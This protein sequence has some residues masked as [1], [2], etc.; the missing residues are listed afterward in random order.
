M[1]KPIFRSCSL[2]PQPGLLSKMLTTIP[3]SWACWGG[4]EFCRLQSA[5]LGLKLGAGKSPTS[6]SGFL[7]LCAS[8]LGSHTL[9]SHW[10]EKQHLM[11]MEVT[12]CIEHHL[13]KSSPQTSKVGIVFIAPSL[14]KRTLSCEEFTEWELSPRRSCSGAGSLWKAPSWTTV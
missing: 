7:S 8:E 10:L 12:V 13:I 3:T 11:R 4:K 14:Q 5:V 9:Y 2:I 6:S 1:G